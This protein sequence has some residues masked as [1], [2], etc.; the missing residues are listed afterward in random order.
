MGQFGRTVKSIQ[1]INSIP[2]FISHSDSDCLQPEFLSLCTQGIQERLHVPLRRAPL[3]PSRIQTLLECE[4]PHPLGLALFPERSPEHIGGLR[5]GCLYG[6]GRCLAVAVDRT[7]AVA[8]AHLEELVANVE[9]VREVDRVQRL[10]A[11]ERPAD[12][13]HASV[14][15]LECAVEAPVGKEPPSGLFGYRF[16]NPRYYCVPVMVCQGTHRVAED[17]LLR[18][19]G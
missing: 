14:D 15:R 9:S 16:V 18:R 4:Q 10:V 5:P 7:Q 3:L 11:D 6:P 2:S 19:P 8:C 1:Y 13:R 17:S 12:Q